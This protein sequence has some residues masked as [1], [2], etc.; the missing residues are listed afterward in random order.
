SD[1]NRVLYWCRRFKRG[2]GP[3]LLP[4]GG[5]VVLKVVYGGGVARG[6]ILA[7][8]KGD[9]GEGYILGGGNTRIVGLLCRD[10]GLAGDPRPFRSFPVGP[11]RPLAI[12]LEGVSRVTRTRPLLRRGLV[13]AL[14]TPWAFSSE[15]SRRVLGYTTI[16]FETALKTT[17][18]SA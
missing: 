2:G 18:E 15:K 7:L 13:R 9:P 1:A 8:R 5:E 11:L 4:G 6:L 3:H 10:A 14:E 17:F 16:P 12:V